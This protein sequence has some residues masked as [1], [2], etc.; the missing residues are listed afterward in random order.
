MASIG[1]EDLARGPAR[2]REE[3]PSALSQARSEHRMGEVAARLVQRGDGEA[4]RLGAAPEASQ[5]RE[6]EPDPVAL[7][8]PAPEL[9]QDGLVYVLLGHEEVTEVMRHGR[10]VPRGRPR[11]RRLGSPTGGLYRVAFPSGPLLRM[12]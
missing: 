9:A 5:L 2:D 10:I 12:T 7:L 3:C 8:A 1:H 4:L 11:Q 6:D